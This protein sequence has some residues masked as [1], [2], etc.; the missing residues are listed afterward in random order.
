MLS[1]KTDYADESR[2]MDQDS[3]LGAHHID[4]AFCFGDCVR[5]GG[6][7]CRRRCRNVAPLLQF[8]HDRRP[9]QARCSERLG[10]IGAP[11]PCKQS[12][13]PHQVVFLEYSHWLRRRLDY[14][15]YIAA[16]RTVDA[17]DCNCVSAF[18]TSVPASAFGCIVRAS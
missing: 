10:R 15:L 4:S 14:W 12:A 5:R 9:K 7:R 16:S 18:L 17:D 2:D 3:V 13:I 1:E 6:C 8:F 11:K